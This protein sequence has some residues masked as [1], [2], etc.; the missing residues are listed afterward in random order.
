MVIYA[1]VFY[2]FSR[3]LL[4]SSTRYLCLLKLIANCLESTRIQV[5]NES[6]NAIRL[7]FINYIK[8]DKTNFW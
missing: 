4:F 7:Y 3:L 5:T 2:I 6:S 1:L 8:S